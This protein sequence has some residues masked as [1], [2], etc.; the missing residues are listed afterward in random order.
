MKILFL[1]MQNSIH[2]ERWIRQLSKSSYCIG[3]YPSVSGQPT[4]YINKFEKIN[5]LSNHK[6][7]KNFFFNYFK[8]NLINKLAIFFL[9]RFK[10][11]F[12]DKFFLYFCIIRFKP[13]II[14]TLEIQH[15]G[16]LYLSLKNSF[17]F[18]NKLKKIKWIITN[19]GSDIF[20]FQKYLGHKKKI[21]L[22]LN[23]ADYYSAECKRDYILAQTYNKNLS[24]LPL[25]PNAG[26]FNLEKVKKLRNRYK[27]NDRNI[28]II[29][30]YVSKFG[31]AD[32]VLEAII[33]MEDIL[34]DYKIIFY[35]ASNFIKRKIT[36][37]NNYSKLNISF[38]KKISHNEM[39]NLFS[40]SK[41]YIGISRSDGLSTS[42]LEA[43][44]LGVFPI[45]SSTSCC[46]E[47]IRHKDTG[48][49]VK[50][51]TV[52]NIQE[53]INF[54][55]SNPKILDSSSKKNWISAKNFLDSEANKKIAN[56]FYKI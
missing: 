29:K 2:T 15:A 28:I 50:S 21:N 48:F 11:L 45:Q 54:S 37:L 26:G 35:S 19:W 47:I 13:D 30:G 53:A 40:K 3:I 16:Y 10:I 39:L 56:S 5:L 23:L 34:K 46:N 18:K 49:I 51:N 1:A 6:T 12:L 52:Q 42:F 20:F 7:F 8:Y 43:I 55:L 14:H 24:F 44:T 4:S 33:K 41:I 38:T 32:I 25:M 27:V 36:S 22:C 17:L 9:K 31:Q